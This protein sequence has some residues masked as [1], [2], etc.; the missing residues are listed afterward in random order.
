MEY[1]L[2]L[3]IGLGLYS[4]PSSIV[5]VNALRELLDHVVKNVPSEFFFLGITTLGYDWTLPYV[6]G[7]TGATAIANNTAIQIAAENNIPYNL[8]KLHNHLLSIIW[9]LM[10]FF[11]WYGL[12]MREVLTHELSW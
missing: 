1:Y 3:M 10:G 2:L 5:P 4:Y 9:I 7:A 12:M 8:V 6:P 11:T